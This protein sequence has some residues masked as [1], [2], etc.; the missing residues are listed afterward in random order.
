[1]FLRND[2]ALGKM[3]TRKQDYVFSLSQKAFPSYQGANSVAIVRLPL[4][5][6]EAVVKMLNRGLWQFHAL[7]SQG[8]RLGLYLLEKF[9]YLLLNNFDGSGYELHI[10]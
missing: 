1:M 10:E 5:S 4:L 2:V 9:V 3:I 7:T 6:S 8:G